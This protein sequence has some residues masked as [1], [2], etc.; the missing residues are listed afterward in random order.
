MSI[1]H[2]TMT[3]AERKL[4]AMIVEILLLAVEG[5]QLEGVLVANVESFGLAEDGRTLAVTVELV[6]G[7]LAMFQF[8]PGRPVT[9]AV[10]AGGTP[11]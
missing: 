2:D 5:P 10:V 11:H 7:R 4:H 9:A 3:A 1:R 8:C 6:D